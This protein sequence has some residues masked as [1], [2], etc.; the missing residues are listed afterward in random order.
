MFWNSRK[1]SITVSRELHDRVAR[2]CVPIVDSTSEVVAVR[3]LPSE[4]PG[5]LCRSI[6]G[7]TEKP[8]SSRFT[9]DN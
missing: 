7:Q 9:R 2:S 4:D 5:P 6:G 1:S 3:R 8:G